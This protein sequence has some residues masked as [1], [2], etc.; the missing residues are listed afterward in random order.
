MVEPKTEQIGTFAASMDIT[1]YH[2][3]YESQFLTNESALELAS[4]LTIDP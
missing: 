1:E 4:I 2:D 3:C